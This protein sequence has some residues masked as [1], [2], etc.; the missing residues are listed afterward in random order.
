MPIIDTT[1]RP[2][3]PKRRLEVIPLSKIV[4][5]DRI[6][7][8][9]GNIDSLAESIQQKGVMQTLVVQDLGDGRYRL[10]AGGRRYAASCKAG[11]AEVPANICEGELTDLELK[12][13]E[14]EEN[15]QRKDLEWAEEVSLKSQIHQLKTAIYG[16]PKTSAK[17]ATGW[18]EQDTARL[19]GDHRTT[20]TRDLTLAA[21]LRKNPEL[22]KCK[23]KVEAYRQVSSQTEKLLKEEL[24]RRFEQTKPDTDAL[25]NNYILG[26]FFEHA[27]ELPSNCV[28]FIELD[29]PW[30]VNYEQHVAATGGSATEC[31]K[32]M[33]PEQFPAF[34]DQTLKECVRLLKPDRWIAIWFS[35]RYH[36]ETI[37]ILCEKHGLSV[38]PIP[39]IWFK[40]GYTGRPLQ[41][42]RGMTSG[43]ETLL[44][45]AKGDARLA[46][47]RGNVFS[48]VPPAQTERTHPTEK[49]V[50]L[51][52]DLFTTFCDGTH[53]ILVPF[54]G[55]G[56][57]ILA[58]N[59][60]GMTCFGYDL[61]ET[62]RNE[63][64]LKVKGMV[65]Q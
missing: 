49:P 4:V 20:I 17:G 57:Q 54:L 22:S 13:I 41:G 38:Y 18:S 29:P 56:N 12:E 5:D 51:M 31:F 47:I 3:Q 25:T 59:R 55:S 37:K 24:A 2:I 36:F 63:F 46:R 44:Y 50:D 53:K 16:G 10:L 33:T 11:L 14:L 65:Q 58:A 6:R 9:M 64:I 23:T 40:P 7:V 30:G 52:C 21:A 26:D 8:E 34:M 28:D 1:I 62:Y 15:I 45:A 61:S 19:L 42:D 48:Y 27:P 39:A 32:D 35:I 43:Y 60:V